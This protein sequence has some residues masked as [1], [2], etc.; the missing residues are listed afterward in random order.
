VLLLCFVGAS[1]P[2]FADGIWISEAEIMALPMS[3]PAWDKLAA[4]ATGPWGTPNISDSGSEHDVLTLAGALYAVRTGDLETRARVEAAIIAAVGT[5]GN[6]SLLS[7]SRNLL[8]YVL[9]ADI[10]GYRTPWYENWVDWYRQKPFG[11]RT[12][13]S[14]HEDRPNNHGTHAGATRIAI[15]LYLGD[16]T[17][18]AR[19]LEWQADPATPVAINPLGALRDGRVFDGLLPEEMR[20]CDCAF[21]PAAPFPQVNYTWGALQGAT[22]QAEILRRAGFPAFEW[23]DQAILRAVRWLEDQAYYAAV[24]DDTWIPYVLNQAYGSD[25]CTAPPG[26]LEVGKAMAYTAWTHP[27]LTPPGLPDAD[28]DCIPDDGDG[29]GVA[30]DSVCTFGVTTGC[31]D[32]C[33]TVANFDQSDRDSDELGDAC[34]VCTDVPNPDQIDTNSDGFGNLCDGDVND[35][36]AVGGPDFGILLPKFGTLAGEPDYDPA[37]DFDSNGAVGGSDFGLFV[38]GF[39]D[40]PGPSGLECAGKTIPCSVP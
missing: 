40:K 33:P 14:Q 13:I 38:N 2:A 4:D 12:M 29:S 9:A 1:I 34:D 7:L 31:D 24:G 3:G 22:V 10:I 11:Q 19:A 30:G 17:D 15:A 16:D 35:D 6:E 36:G 8:A 37:L 20:R 23:E 39:G 18:L 5:E 25:L 27:D 28:G 21:D 26:A 32:S